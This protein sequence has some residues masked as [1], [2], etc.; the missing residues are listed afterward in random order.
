MTPAFKGDS[1]D[2]DD[3]ELYTYKDSS[4]DDDKWAIL[5]RIESF[6]ESEE[7][8]AWPKAAMLRS[9]L[10]AFFDKPVEK[11]ITRPGKFLETNF[12]IIAKQRQS[13]MFLH[14]EGKDKDILSSVGYYKVYDNL[15]WH[16]CGS[17]C[18]RMLLVTTHRS[19][20]NFASYVVLISYSVSQTLFH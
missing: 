6:E 10:T 19:L 9:K 2:E 15:H 4:D 20:I 1:D 5:K 18:Y 17:T 14:R 12:D 7:R 13:E 11:S 8:N 3:I 16:A